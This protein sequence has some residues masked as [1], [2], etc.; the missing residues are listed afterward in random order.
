MS[1]LEVWTSPVVSW[2]DLRFSLALAVMCDRNSWLQWRARQFHS[3]PPAMVGFH[4]W[5][6]TCLYFGARL[7]YWLQRKWWPNAGLEHVVAAIPDCLERSGALLALHLA[8]LGRHCVR[9]T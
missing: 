1:V 7:L 2:A 5:R 9:Q 8:C 3:E 4:S 6:L